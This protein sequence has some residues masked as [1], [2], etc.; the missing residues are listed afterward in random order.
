[1]RA[2]NLRSPFYGPMIIY[3]DNPPWNID[4]QLSKVIHPF[5]ASRPFP[6]Q[7]W[8]NRIQRLRWTRLTHKAQSIRQPD[9]LCCAVFWRFESATTPRHL[10]QWHCVSFFEYIPTVGRT[11]GTSSQ[12][13]CDW[14]RKPIYS[15]HRILLLSVAQQNVFKSEPA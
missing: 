15:L 7:N 4:L 9:R 3:A 6:Q 5:L 12:W 11:R 14:T 2:K 8:P 10:P 1:M 13:E